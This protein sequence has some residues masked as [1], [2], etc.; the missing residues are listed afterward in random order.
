MPVPS[1]PSPPPFATS[2]ARLRPDG[3]EAAAVLGWSVLLFVG[4]GTLTALWP[5]P[6]FVRMTAVAPLDFAL[7]AAEAVLLGAYFGLR[8]ACV[9][10]G[11]GVGGVL[12]FL[13]FGCVLCNKLLLLAFGATALLTWFEPYRH[14]VGVAGVAIL[15]ALLWRKLRRRAAARLPAEWPV[16]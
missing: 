7:L 13:G 6:V 11:A 16:T 5:N 10:P 9:V 15:A 3:R 14:A 2:I 1:D 4:L 12:G 8:G